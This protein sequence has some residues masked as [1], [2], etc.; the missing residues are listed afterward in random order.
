M[1]GPFRR[2]AADRKNIV[3]SALAASILLG[4]IAFYAPALAQWPDPFGLWS[5]RQPAARPDAL[6]YVVTIAGAEG[7]AALTAVVRDASLLQQTRDDPPRDGVELAR[8]VEA[9]LPRLVDALWSRG[10]YAATVTVRIGEAEA[11][12]GRPNEG[13][14]ARAA[15]RSRNV[16]AAPVTILLSPGPVYRLS[17]PEVVEAGS[18]RPFAPEVLPPRTVGLE[19]GEPAAT[20][21]VLAAAA[22]LSDRFRQRGHPFVR[23]SR[24]APV[25][26]HPSRMVDLGFI[27]DPGPVADLGQITVTGT[28]AVDPAVVRSFIYAEPGQ[29]YSPE[30]IAAIRRS[31]SRIEAIGAVR[32]REGQAL[33]AAGGLPLEV[34]VTERLPR[35]VGASARY[36]TTDGPAA[37]A[38][39]VHRNLFG[40]AERLRL[41]A[42]LFY[43]VL[44]RDGR[45]RR[46]RQFEWKDLG[47]R[48]AASFLKPALGGT[49]FDL[50]ADVALQRERTE[51]YDADTGLATLAIR[52]RFTDAA[53]LQFGLEGEIGRIERAPPPTILLPP[54]A[55]DPFARRFSYGLLGLPLSF[56]YDSTDRPLDPTTGI[57]LQGS[58]TPFLGFGDAAPFFGIGRLQASG[59]WA[60]DPEA[61]TIIAARLGFG[62]ILGAAASDIPATRLFFA[63]GGGSVRGFD[64]RSLGPRDPF[65]RPVGGRSLVE[66]SLEARI[67]ITDTIGLVPFV[68]VGQAFA[69]P[70]PSRSEPLRVGA[71]LGLR[72]YTPI[73][74]IRVDVAVPVDR[75][76][77][78]SPYALYV[79][80]GQ[81]F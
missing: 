48:V 29:P 13:A 72:Y 26:D 28:R 6:P 63:G 64:H 10:H 22:R 71:G 31:V 56:T 24:R 78:E 76:R 79:S 25:I 62:T 39:W 8:R 2:R 40:G 66:G 37:R 41:E 51:G 35:L 46:G 77:G 5:E 80:I 73:G 1:S 44:D 53:S 14:L 23:V 38:Y 55:I 43:T 19:G 7:D 30:A 67:R 36:S 68:D 33:D 27:V 69:G 42:D 3:R 34:E 70:L 16:A 74:P 17:R 11:A 54:G 9:D 50:L 20:A 61:R 4:P 21:A 45:E 81:A 58:A 18:R 12:L 60:L 59:Y 75:R 49:R 52:R 15:E 47:G 57:R 32:V 65:G